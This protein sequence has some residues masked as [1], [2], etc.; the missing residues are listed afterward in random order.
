VPSELEAVFTPALDPLELAC[1]AGSVPAA[2]LVVLLLEPLPHAASR[3]ETAT[4]GMDSFSAWRICS[5]LCVESGAPRRRV[6]PAY[7]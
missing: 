5:L 2:E 6:I 3:S 1:V 4:A 7:T